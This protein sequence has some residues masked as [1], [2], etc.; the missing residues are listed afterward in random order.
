MTNDESLKHIQVPLKLLQRRVFVSFFIISLALALIAPNVSFAAESKGH[1]LDKYIY[2]PTVHPLTIA[3]SA[4]ARAQAENKYTLLVLG[5][6]W[7]HDSRGLAETFSNNQMQGILNQ[8]YVTEF[9]DVGF[10]ED[11][12]ELTEYVGYPTYFATPTVL[13]IDPKTKQLVNL[14][15]LSIWQNAASVDLSTY[16]D[17]FG[18]WRYDEKNTSPLP[19]VE[20]SEA[21]R[22][23]AKRLQAGYAVLGPMLDRS[24]NKHADADAEQEAFFAL[25]DEVKAFRFALQQDIHANRKSESSLV[26]LTSKY[27]ALHSWESA[28]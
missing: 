28:L 9:I 11:R 24:A 4:L 21:E 14:D 5:A 13:I 19:S 22:E 27:D 6:Q 17:E 25:W 23:Q 15:S 18:K 1:V 8:N 7:C 12:R 16:M 10:L 3:K 2:T 20:V 26:K